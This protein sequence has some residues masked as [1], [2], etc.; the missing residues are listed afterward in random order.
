[1]IILDTSV[2][3]E[4]F[5]KKA[6][7]FNPVKKL[8]ETEEVYALEC[9]FGELLQGAKDDREIELIISYW[10]YLPK[11]NE[12]NIW[13]DAGKY[14]AK[15]KLTT[16]G[17]GLLDAVIIIAAIRSKSKIWTLDKKLRKILSQE[18]MYA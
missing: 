16:K 17:V 1:M 14:S 9:I 11:I 18:I 7:I 13:I 4:F 3:I 10:E 2:W 15:N 5:K 8:L 6:E 12:K